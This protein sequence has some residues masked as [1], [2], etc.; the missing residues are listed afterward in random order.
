MSKGDLWLETAVQVAASDAE[1]VAEVLRQR[2]P[3][4]VAIEC[5]PSA[6]DEAL[7]KAYLPVA[8]AGRKVLISLKLALRFLPLSRP[9]RWRRTRRLWDKEWQEGWK[10]Y[11]TPLRV[12]RR[13]VVRPSWA[14]YAAK[15]GD[16]VVEI[17]PGLAFGTGQH[18]TTAMCLRALESLL[19]PDMRVLDVGTG[20]G[21]LAIAA[22]KLGASQV[23]AL[24][25]DPLAVKAAQANAAANRVEDFVQAQEGTLREEHIQSL[26]PFHL[27]LANLSGETVEAM[28]PLLARALA[29][30]GLLVASGFLEE[31]AD[32]LSRRLKACGLVVKETLAEGVWRAL[33]AQLPGEAAR[34]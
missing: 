4:G 17:D 34:T 13:L 16:V 1:L 8:T 9:P 19:R 7:V 26:P 6:D 29:T 18:P 30:G 5:G 20:S 32:N 12:G 10:R 2:C 11:F 21:I 23:L 28:A 3:G 22:A 33:V 14:Q 25:I 15:P 31:A 24:D 27:A